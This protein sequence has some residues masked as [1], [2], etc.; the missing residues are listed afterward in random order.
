MFKIEPDKTIASKVIDIAIG[1]TFDQVLDKVTADERDKLCPYQKCEEGCPARVE[2]KC[3]AVRRLHRA[4]K[5]VASGWGAPRR[6][7]LDFAVLAPL[8]DDSEM[9]PRVEDLSDL[10]ITQEALEGI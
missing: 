1:D 5:K 2:G 8:S 4:P 10:G 3:A 6:D 9:M 7:R